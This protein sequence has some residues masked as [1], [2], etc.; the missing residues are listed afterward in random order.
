MKNCEFLLFQT[1]IKKIHE[2]WRCMFKDFTNCDSSVYQKK[3]QLKRKYKKFQPTKLLATSLED[4]VPEFPNF[5]KR[6][7]L[8]LY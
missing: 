7:K 2:T 1:L 5:D 6:S 8:F 4:E 3:N